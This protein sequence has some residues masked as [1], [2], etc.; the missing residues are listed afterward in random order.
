[1]KR[2][3]PE[4]KS[5]FLLRAEDTRAKWVLL[6][7]ISNGPSPRGGRVSRF[8]ESGVVHNKEKGERR[9]KA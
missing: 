4:K 9:K 8:G 5:D 6:T 3:G 2:K 7:A 1:M